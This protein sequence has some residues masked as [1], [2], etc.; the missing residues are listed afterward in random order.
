MTDWN[1]LKYK[2][3][4]HINI[5]NI[6]N[7]K[8]FHNSLKELETQV[9]GDFFEY[10]CKLYFVLDI[11][12]KQHY[13]NFYLYTEIP[14]DIKKKLKL[15]DKDKGIDA[16]VYDNNDNIYA[17]QIKY[18]KKIDNNISFGEQCTFQA[19]T[20]GTNVKNIYKGIFFTSCIDVY[21]KKKND[22]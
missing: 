15:P 20:F 9:K 6:N 5:N 13:K 16:I 11:Y 2:F 21:K 3:L 4:D 19:L 22:K 17:I 8:D 18:R 14:S 12:S 1:K 7:F 10:F